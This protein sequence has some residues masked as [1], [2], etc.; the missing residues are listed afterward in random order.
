MSTCYFV[1]ILPVCIMSTAPEGTY[2]NG[3]RDVFRHVM[4]EEGPAALFRGLTP[5]MLRAFPANA[6]SVIMCCTLLIKL[7]NTGYRI[8]L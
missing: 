5:V 1:L 6:V 4:K 7:V 8:I 3:V 2:P